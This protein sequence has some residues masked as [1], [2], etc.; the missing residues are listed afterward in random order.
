MGKLRLRELDNFPQSVTVIRSG[1]DFILKP[2]VLAL[3]PCCMNM[4]D[5]TIDFRIWED[6]FI[7]L[8]QLYVSPPITRLRTTIS[9]ILFPFI[10]LMNG[11]TVRKQGA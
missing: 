3:K 10:S 9:L 6:V 1:K 8:K 4:E 11:H 7:S 5:Y 2:E